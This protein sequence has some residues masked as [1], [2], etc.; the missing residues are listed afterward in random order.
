MIN[1]TCQI[2]APVSRLSALPQYV[3]RAV[4]LT[5]Q[6]AVGHARGPRAVTELGPEQSMFGDGCQLD[7]DELPRPDLP[8]TVGLDGGYVHS[9][10]QSLTTRRLV[11]KV[12]QS[13][14]H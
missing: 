1:L 6:R 7:W 9:S 8:L 10:Q 12:C 2:L 14:I 3:L 4:E 11:R 5:V 13:T